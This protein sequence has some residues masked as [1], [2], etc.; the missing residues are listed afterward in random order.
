MLGRKGEKMKKLSVFLVF[1]ILISFVNFHSLGR[2]FIEEP[3]TRGEFE[4]AYVTVRNNFNTN[5]DDVNVKMYIYDLGLMYSS[6][7]SDVS[8]RDHVVQRLFIRVPE[9]VPAGEYLTKISVGNDQFR[10]TQ[11]IFL[12]IV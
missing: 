2:F 1:L 11:H 3:L 6:V 9:N 7:A 5:V 12:D 8:K 10:D 4:T